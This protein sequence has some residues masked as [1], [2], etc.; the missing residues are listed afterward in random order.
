[1]RQRQSM[2]DGVVESMKLL[3][4]LILSSRSNIGKLN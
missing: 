4:T 3:I 1:M 2:A